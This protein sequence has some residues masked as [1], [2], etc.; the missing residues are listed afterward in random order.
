MS[1]EEMINGLIPSSP[2]LG[3]TIAIPPFQVESPVSE[4]GQFGSYV[5]KCVEG[6]KEAGNPVERR[7]SSHTY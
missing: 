6:D 5:W 4:S 2:V 3:E 7:K 1:F